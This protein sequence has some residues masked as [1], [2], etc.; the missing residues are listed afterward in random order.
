MEEFTQATL[1]T[2]PFDVQLRIM[3]RMSPAAILKL[4]QVSSAFADICRDGDLWAT[5]MRFH[6]PLFELTNDPHAQFQALTAGV[7]TIY[8]MRLDV[9]G[10]LFNQALLL[11]EPKEFWRV[12]VKVK[13]LPIKGKFWVAYHNLDFDDHTGVFS[14]RESAARTLASNAID[15]IADTLK[16][17]ADREIGVVNYDSMN[18][19]AQQYNLP[20]PFDNEEQWVETL[21]DRGIIT[22][23]PDDDNV[24]FRVWQVVETEFIV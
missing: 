13:G 9:E 15:E 2:V 4:C 12:P 10:G 24:T 7:V 14:D 19:V 16:Y 5:L 21:M 11:R 1:E 18:T 22:F 3:E 17:L 23:D 8:Y 20:V 6:Y